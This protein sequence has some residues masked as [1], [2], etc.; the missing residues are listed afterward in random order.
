MLLNIGILTLCFGKQT[1]IT[2]Y[3]EELPWHVDCIPAGNMESHEE[4]IVRMSNSNS[5]EDKDAEV[6]LE[7]WVKGIQSGS[8]KRHAM[9]RASAYLV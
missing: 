9:S 5:F 4:K 1:K 7:G 3:K 2:R 6:T 8:N